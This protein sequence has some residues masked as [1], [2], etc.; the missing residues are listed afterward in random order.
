MSTFSPE[1]LREMERIRNNDPT[2][3][4]CGGRDQSKYLKPEKR[5]EQS[6]YN[7]R[8]VKPKRDRVIYELQRADELRHAAIQLDLNPGSLRKLIKEYNLEGYVNGN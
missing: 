8:S 4:I 1:A 3:C 7:Y 2:L 6:N 5:I